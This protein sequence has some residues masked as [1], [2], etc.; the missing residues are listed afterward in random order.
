MPVEFALSIGHVVC[1][2]RHRMVDKSIVPAPSKLILC[3]VHLD[4]HAFV[5]SKCSLFPWISRQPLRGW[6]VCWRVFNLLRAWELRNY[7]WWQLFFIAC[8]FVCVCVCFTRSSIR[9]IH[10]Q[11]CS[12]YA[13]RAIFYFSVNE[14]PVFFCT[15]FRRDLFS[16]NLYNFCAHCLYATIVDCCLMA[17]AV[18]DSYQPPT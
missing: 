7:K 1:C 8:V 17:H 12:R 2:L 6:G 16:L 11:N 15:E 4:I 9:Q 13:G 18:Q 3:L 5:A 14:L 10:W